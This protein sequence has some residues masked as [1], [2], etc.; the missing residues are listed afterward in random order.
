MEKHFTVQGVKTLFYYFRYR[1]GIIIR[2]K[3]HA[4]YSVIIEYTLYR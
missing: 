3:N 1:I 4:P 2:A